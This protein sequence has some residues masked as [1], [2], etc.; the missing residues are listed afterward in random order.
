[1]DP[2]RTPEIPVTLPNISN[3][4]EAIEPTKNPPNSANTE[5]FI[6]GPIE[7]PNCWHIEIYFSLVNEQT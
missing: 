4:K 1:M 6:C 5:A 2:A 7:R 3:L